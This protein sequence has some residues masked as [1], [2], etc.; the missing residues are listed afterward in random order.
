MATKTLSL[1]ID[2]ELIERIDALVEDGQSRN[3]VIKGL[4]E[5]GLEAKSGKKTDE[6]IFQEMSDKLVERVVERVSET[7]TTDVKDANNELFRDWT[8]QL[9]ATALPTVLVPLLDE[10]NKQLSAEIEALKPA[11]PDPQPEVES[12]ETSDVP[13]NTEPAVEEKPSVWKRFSNWLN[14]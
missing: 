6:E 1:R 14:S 10:R 11:E 2:E 4:I 8:Q 12:S 5:A 13:A 7:V 3:A 9:T